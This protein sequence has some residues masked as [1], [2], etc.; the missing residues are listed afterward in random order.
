MGTWNDGLLDN[1]IACDALGDL[2]GEIR[3]DIERFA[4]TPNTIAE[5]CAAVGVLLQLSTY[6][7]DVE[8]DRG[9]DELSF[10]EGNY[11]N[12][13]AALALLLKGVTAAR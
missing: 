7:F 5:L 2:C 3:D 11:A 4:G 8:H 1:D 10:H 13:D 9:A 6:D 12:V